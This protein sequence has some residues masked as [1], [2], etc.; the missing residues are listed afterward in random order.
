MPEFKLRDIISSPK[1]QSGERK[2]GEVSPLFRVKSLVSGDT[3]DS[4]DCSTP[5]TCQ[6]LLQ[7]SERAA[8]T[9]RCYE[10]IISYKSDEG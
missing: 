7:S 6:G 1:R 3:E 9:T 8:L 4:G 2:E 10:Y 5:L